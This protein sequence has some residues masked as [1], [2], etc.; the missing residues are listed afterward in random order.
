VAWSGEER[1]TDR[2]TIRSDGSGIAYTDEVPHDRDNHGVLWRR[3]TLSPGQGRPVFGTIH[4]ARQRRVARKLLCNVCAGPADRNDDGVLWLLGDDRGDW[5]NWPETMGATHPPICLP[6]AALSVRL[7]PHLREGGH[8]A[9]RVREPR[10][11]GVFGALY[12]PGP[13]GP[14]AVEPV[15][16][17][18]GDWRQP[19]VMAAQAATELHGCTLVDLDAELAAAGI[20]AGPIRPT[21]P[22]SS[23]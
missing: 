20:E 2:L 4:A 8:V 1:P 23:G 9:V 6:C 12:A 3:S 19:W 15:T 11:G 17:P 13:L 5:P 14:E 18:Y 16:I 21:A 7:C 10:A 22:A